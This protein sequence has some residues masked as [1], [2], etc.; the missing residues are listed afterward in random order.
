MVFAWF[1]PQLSFSEVGTT[2][3]NWGH[4]C[5]TGLWK[6]PFFYR[7]REGGLAR[8]RVEIKWPETEKASRNTRLP[9]ET[10]GLVSRRT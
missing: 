3:Q 10:H 7:T 6:S 2:R 8:R 5:N 1:Y 4:S 9:P